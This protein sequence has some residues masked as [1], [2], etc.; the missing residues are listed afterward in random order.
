MKGNFVVKRSCN[1]FNQVPLDQATKWMNRMCKISNGITGST[2]NDPARDQFCATC[3]RLNVPM[4]PMK[5]KSY[6]DY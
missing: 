4:C 6:L 5:Q 1:H 2:Q 3:I